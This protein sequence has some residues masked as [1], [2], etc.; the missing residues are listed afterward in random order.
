[1]GT[2]TATTQPIDVATRQLSDGNSSGTI[3]GQSP[4]DKIGFYGIS[5]GVVQPASK[6]GKAGQ[7]GT[8]TVYATTQ[9]PT[10]VAPN[11]S[12]EQALTVTGVAT[13]QLVIV[14]KPTAQAG[15]VLGT[16][17]VSASNT[18]QVTFGNDT[19]ATIT[20]T[21]SETYL[22]TAI[23]ATMV[24]TAVLSPSAVQPNSTSTQFFAVPDVGVNAAVQVNKPTAQ[25]GLIIT[26]AD[27]NAAGILA[28]TFANLTAA[29][30]TPTASESYLV[31]CVQGI[32]IAPV[33]STVM[34]TLTPAAVA[35]NTS[36]EQTFTV[37]GLPAGVPVIVNKPTAQNGLSIGG[38]RVSAANTLAI[39]F[40]N[41]TAATITPT[42]TEVYTVGYFPGTTPAAGSSTAYSGSAGGS[43]H[44]DLVAMGLVAGP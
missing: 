24:T 4:L 43:N 40:V 15:L 44:A 30:I 32:G 20:P 5:P 35:P 28:I 22:V 17:R 3:L 18:I 13:G 16:A 12:A 34:P 36:A 19:A 14:N 23:P 8:V 33:E 41:N 25:A 1:M 42:A 29:T 21:A 10:S 39:T 9:S 7:V 2:T 38:A 6:G 27:S 11:T 26:G 37:A 31:F